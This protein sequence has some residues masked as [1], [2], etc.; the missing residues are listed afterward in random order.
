M[1]E[2]KKP[3]RRSPLS[4]GKTKHAS[5]SFRERVFKAAFTLFREQGF[6]RP[7]LNNFWERHGKCLL[8]VAHHF[9]HKP[10]TAPLQLCA[11]A[12]PM[13]RREI[14]RWGLSASSFLHKPM[15]NRRWGEALR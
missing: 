2:I 1:S 12:E 10:M 5:G 15:F 7:L 8:I 14:R 11:I 4:Q 3:E 9:E 6:S 13:M